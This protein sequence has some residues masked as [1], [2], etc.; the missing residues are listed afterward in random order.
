MRRFWDA[1]AKED[2]FYFVD[3]TLDYGN[4]DTD[5]FW[6]SGPADVDRVLDPLGVGIDPQCELVEVGCGLGRMTRALAAQAR[7]VR[8]VDVSREMLEQARSYNPNL[9][10]V[11][12]ILGDGASLSG[13]SSKSAD[14]CFSF[15]VFQHIPDPDVTM[16]YVRE[17]GRVLRPSAWAAFQVSTL[18]EVHRR[19]SLRWRSA[20]AFRAIRGRSPQG[21]SHPAWRGSSVS[22]PALRRVADD[23]GMDTE[24]VVGEG[25]QFCFVLLRKRPAAA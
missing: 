4:P 22:L 10:N 5:R 13:V 20:E 9:A 12:W 11:E 24:R 23:A 25:T 3:S 14:A 19:R 21:R 15:V 7:S 2:A 16:G 17:M 18:A 1:R 8:A 6:A